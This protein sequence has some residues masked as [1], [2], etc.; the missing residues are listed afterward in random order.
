MAD[1]LARLIARASFE[2]GASRTFDTHETDSGGFESSRATRLNSEVARASFETGASRTFDTHDIGSEC[3]DGSRGTRFETEVLG[4][5]ASWLAELPTPLTLA[6]AS[7]QRPLRVSIGTHTQC[8]L[9]LFDWRE[10][11]A[12]VDAVENDRG[13]PKHFV[14][15]STRKRR[16]PTWRLTPAE[17]MGCGIYDAEPG[18]WTVNRVLRRL[19]LALEAV[20][21][22]D[23]AQT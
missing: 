4:F 22:P 7:V 21:V 2:T 18:H 20:H 19:G 10:W 8:P 23:D 1:Y 12:M 16:R 3:F 11:L 5:R 6:V 13:W 17:A 9:A 14:E 15:W